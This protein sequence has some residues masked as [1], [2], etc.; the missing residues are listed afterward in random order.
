MNFNQL[1]Q[2]CWGI[3]NWRKT[4]G[5]QSIVYIHD[6]A[7]VVLK[8]PR[9]PDEI[10]KVKPNWTPEKAS[11][12]AE[13]T[14]RGP[15]IADQCLVG[16][17]SVLEFEWVDWQQLGKTLDTLDQDCFKPG[18][19]REGTI[20]QERA[21]AD[22]KNYLS[23]AG[24]RA[25]LKMVLKGWVHLNHLFWQKAVFYPLFVCASNFGIKYVDGQ[26]SVRLLDLGE[27][28]QNKKS[29]EEYIADIEDD[30]TTGAISSTGITGTP[31]YRFWEV[32]DS[33]KKKNSVRR[34]LNNDKSFA[35]YVQMLRDEIGIA[36]FR[37]RWI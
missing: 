31:R 30:L 10:Q 2:K 16:T 15:R 6:T 24:N 12:I 9:T 3:A 35:D 32:I 1:L 37:K 19:T 29:A 8:I 5:V 28:S 36:Q 11:K 7:G 20:V 22:L 34:L 17:E 4:G 27:L 26:P 33:K 25:S 13:L 18:E 14:T 21:D 23:D